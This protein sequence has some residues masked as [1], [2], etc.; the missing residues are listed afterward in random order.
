MASARGGAACAALV[1]VVTGA[2]AHAPPLA[3][4][5]LSAPDGGA[6]VIV[7]NRGLVFRDP[8]SGA[9]RLLCNEA[10][11]VNSAE[12]PNVAM[13][14]DGA[15]IVASSAGL[16]LSRDQGC[17][18][19]ELDGLSA[20]SAPALAQDPR[21]PDTLVVATY[22]GAEPGL[23]VTHD[24]G[25]TWTLALATDPSDYVRSLLASPADPASVYATVTTFTSGAR[26][27]HS[28]LRTRD[29][30]QSWERLPLPLL[31]TDNAAIA[32]ASAPDDANSVA[33]YT[34]ANSPGLDDGQL[35]L[36]GDG[37]E[38]F[39]I[40]F[41]RPEIR[42]ATFASDGQL[43]VAARDG[44]F[45]AAPN[46]LAFE[47]VSAATQL[48]C[49]QEWGSA[50]L[51]CGHYAG[52]ATP[53]SG[54]GVFDPQSERF[55]R[56]FD[57]EG[58]ASRV[59]CPL[60]SASEILCQGPWRDWQAELLTGALGGASGAAGAPG[61]WPGAMPAASNAAPAAASPQPLPAGSA[62]AGADAAAACDLA[63]ARGHGEQGHAWLALSGLALAALRRRR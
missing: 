15:L 60:D 21:D 20:S 5:V 52:E 31:E 32:A 26:P 7:T 22:G 23:H 62:S 33:L 34:I 17:S 40:V 53:A 3:A 8:A 58:V 51:A 43:W 38:S 45:G 10:L 16:R 36:S 18:W 14:S 9:T 4:R 1:L 35:L 47:Q 11:H 24:G 42:A 19:A 48:G 30:G 28:L 13:T 61:W 57:F 49:V 39:Q 41:S 63:S 2:A 54:V 56:L 29:S 6:D 12:L 55:Q 25:A 50:L 46:A 44:L 27:T 37:G 59:S